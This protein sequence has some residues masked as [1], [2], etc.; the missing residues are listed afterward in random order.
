MRRLL[1]E[2]AAADDELMQPRGTVR[3]TPP[4]N[5]SEF[6]I[7]GFPI[8]PV[9]TTAAIA[10]ATSTLTK[11]NSIL[12]PHQHLIIDG[13]AR[14]DSPTFTATAAIVD[15]QQS[16]ASENW[17]DRAI[18]ASNVDPEEVDN[19]I[20]VT[21]APTQTATHEAAPA[22]VEVTPTSAAASATSISLPTQTDDAASSVTT[23][24]GTRGT[25]GNQGDDVPLQSGG[26]PNV[27]APA[28]QTA[29]S[30]CDPDG[31]ACIRVRGQEFYYS[32]EDVQ[33]TLEREPG[34]LIFTRSNWNLDLRS[35]SI[36]NNW[37]CGYDLEI[38]VLQD[39]HILACFLKDT[40][41][42]GMQTLHNEYMLKLGEGKQQVKRSYG[43]IQ[44]V[45]SLLDMAVRRNLGEMP[46]LAAAYGKAFET[47]PE[48]KHRLETEL[49]EESTASPA[50]E[51]L[52]ETAR[53][54]F[55]DGLYSGQAYEAFKTFQT[56]AIG[57][58]IGA[59]RIDVSTVQR[60]TTPRE[61][62][63]LIVPQLITALPTFMQYA[64]GMGLS[65]MMGGDL[66][67]TPM[68]PIIPENIANPEA[69]DPMSELEAYFRD[70]EPT[71]MTAVYEHAA[72]EPMHGGAPATISED[73]DSDSD[74]RSIRIEAPGTPNG[75][76]EDDFMST[77]DSMSSHRPLESR[78]SI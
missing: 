34:C 26:A 21:V 7:N 12:A 52:A 18:V 61:L 74:M 22:S 29:T 30:A 44:L 62:M 57:N 64:Q 65:E 36:I 1:Q 13:A 2:D 37:I 53:T 24:I 31:G 70:R 58:L 46:S 14:P 38:S 10:M 55:S 43:N 42:L 35:Y 66:P 68:V 48:I 15:Q 16:A 67:D 60:V 25:G 71:G 54:W 51:M 76:Q 63:A 56:T 45:L 19:R 40:D 72:V 32:S 78:T 50:M 3:D 59:G 39:R 33:R 77:L 47:N 4:Y 6:N 23:S 28:A 27:R 20:T 69:A 17:I 73:S 41:R 9:Q 75:D 8:A 5:G 11:Q 49:L